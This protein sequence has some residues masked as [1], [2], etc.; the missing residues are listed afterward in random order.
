MAKTH[1]LR[2]HGNMAKFL[3][4]LGICSWLLVSAT[5]HNCQHQHPKAHEVSCVRLAPKMKGLDWTLLG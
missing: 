1:P 4:A 5:A 2:P 3:A